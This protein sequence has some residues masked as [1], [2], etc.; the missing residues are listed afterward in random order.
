MGKI[1]LSVLLYTTSYIAFPQESTQEKLSEIL[2]QANTTN[3]VDSLLA[4]GNDLIGEWNDVIYVGQIADSVARQIEYTRGSALANKLLGIPYYYQ[5][6]PITAVR[7]WDL[8]IDKYNEIEDV[9]GLSNMQNNIGSLYREQGELV[10]ALE[11]FTRSLENAEKIKDEDARTLRIAS[12]LYGIGNVNSD[13]PDANVLAKDYFF[14]TLPLALEIEDNFIV[15]NTYMGIGELYY[16]ASMYDSALY[17][18]GKAMEY[19]DDPGFQSY[20]L[21]YLGRS[22]VGLSQ[23]EEALDL[24]EQAIVTAGEEY[25][26]DQIKALLGLGDA[27]FTFQQYNKALLAYMKARDLAIESNSEPELRDAYLG[28][29]RT[30][31]KLSEFSNAYHYQNLYVNLKDSIFNQE[32]SRRLDRQQYSLDLNEKDKAILQQEAEARTRQIIL[33]STIG[34]VF[35]GLVGVYS[36]FRYVRR[37]NKIIADEKE[38]SENLL[39]NILP[40]E[41]AEELK[42]NGEAKARKFEQVSI[43]F[44]DF[45]GFTAVA[46]NLEPEELVKEIH[47]RYKMFDL[48]M[49]RHGVEKIKTIGDAYMAAGGLPVTND[50]HPFDVVK[51]AIDIRDYMEKVKKEHQE[52]G[53]P[54]FEVR[55]GIHTGPVVAGIVGTKKFAYDIWGDTVNIASRMESNSEPGRIN[56]SE[57]T[58]E[59]IK[60]NYSCQ[61]RGEI[62]AKNRGKLKMYFVDYPI[63]TVKEAGIKT[64]SSLQN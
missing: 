52:A 34:V 44:T 10:T 13:I 2:K 6:D 51:A 41:T 56:I 3:K 14:R 54:F 20:A 43:L 30:Y 47:E 38:R 21:N 37:T 62:E 19:D 16:D 4:I 24:H 32:T 1:L 57:T 42:V 61:F 40:A 36:R 35:L 33:G 58:Y 26:P 55:I 15:A 9:E 23:Y 53:K 22:Y 7:Y 46:A 28:L 60:D 25:M 8:S 31:E 48:I 12:A 29:A 64:D 50:T 11:Y 59:I 17:Y 45:K 63:E 5:G 27:H 18:I 49:T 39:L